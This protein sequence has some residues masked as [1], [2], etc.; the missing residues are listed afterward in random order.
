MEEENFQGKF[1][2]LDTDSKSAV[3]Q[4][5]LAQRRDDKLLVRAPAISKTVTWRMHQKS[6]NEDFMKCES[7][8]KRIF[9]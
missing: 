6:S 4:K 9:S 7:R 5:N 8:E 2:F 3:F 1:K